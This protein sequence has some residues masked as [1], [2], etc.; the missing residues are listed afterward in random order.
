MG[1]GAP[2]C[3]KVLQVGAE[4]IVFVGCDGG[5]GTFK[6]LMQLV[7][8]PERSLEKSSN[9]KQDNCN[10]N[11]SKKEKKVILR[12]WFPRHIDREAGNFLYLSCD[13]K[14]TCNCVFISF[15]S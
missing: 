3:V 7:V 2:Q 1:R 9:T 14:L 11:L 10:L 13:V 6:S 4:V 5:F 15:I 8:G 12:Q